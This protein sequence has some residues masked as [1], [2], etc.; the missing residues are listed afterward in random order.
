MK[1][2]QVVLVAALALAGCGTVPPTHTPLPSGDFKNASSIN[3]SSEPAVQAFWRTFDDPLLEEL[4][5][6][7][8]AANLDLRA[9]QARLRQARAVERQSQFDLVPKITAGA[10]YTEARSSAASLGGLSSL[11]PSGITHPPPYH[12]AP[13]KRLK[14]W[15]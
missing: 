10:G 6:K 14:G 4:A 2:R 3:F 12:A 1:Y 13:A 9:A 11:V 15:R 5:A 8:I 7:A